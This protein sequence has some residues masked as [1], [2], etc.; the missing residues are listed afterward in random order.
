MTLRYYPSHLFYFTLGVSLIVLVFCFSLAAYLY[1]QQSHSAEVL[2]ENI[3]S[4]G[5]ALN[6][7]VT[8]NDLLA[9]HQRGA[10]QV[11]PLW[12]K[13]QQFQ[14]EIEEYADKP[15]EQKIALQLRS[16]LKEYEEL[17]TSEKKNS[18]KQLRLIDLLQKE[19]IPAVQALRNFNGDQ[20]RDSEA[21]HRNILKHMAWGLAIVGGLGSIAGI[22]FGYGLARS[23]RF[24]LDQLLIRVQGAS[25]KLNQEIPL[26]EVVQSPQGLHEIS[27]SL[28][29]QVEQAVQTLQQRE[30]EVRRAEQ[31][32]TVGQ[33]ASGIAHEIRNPLT[34]IKLLVQCV[35]QDPS[36]GKLTQED[37][38][39]IESEIRRMELS[40]QTFLDYARPPKLERAHVNLA[41]VSQEA[42]QLVRGK[43]DQQLVKLLACFP[44]EPV[45]LSV[46]RPQIRQVFVNLYLNAIDA[47]PHG[48]TLSVSLTKPSP[49]W[50]ECTIEDTG[51]GIAADILPRLFQPF[52]SGKETGVG[53]GLV[54]S[55]RIVTEHGGK[56]TGTNRPAGGACFVI[57]LPTAKLI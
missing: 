36:S 35:L 39:L 33:L 26:A 25:D 17:L 24:N 53:L 56:L 46:D 41:V 47:M 45:M 16:Q 23:L 44:E 49:E 30:R 55:Q 43:A 48:G 50:V 18:E 37:L 34:S 51:N 22:V 11:D 52:V 14:K 21:S 27:Q 31:L 40:I 4:R 6:L 20:L 9:L 3:G 5:A 38:T 54:V 12:E 15:E 42:L 32:A 1:S 28:V 2:G 19:M 29:T 7:E 57:R 10:D 8:L 13:V